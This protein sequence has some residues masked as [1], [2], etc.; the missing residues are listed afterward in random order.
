MRAS[1]RFRRLL[2]LL[3]TALSAGLTASLGFWQLGRADQK[4]QIEADLLAK[5]AEPPLH[6]SDL[7]QAEAMTPWINR[8]AR[9][10][11]EWVTQATVFLDN[12]QMDGR[13]GFY[14]VTP[15]RLSGDGRWLL[16]QRGWVPRDFQDRSRLPK[17]PTPEGVVSVSGRIAASPSRVYALGDGDNGA[18]RQNL[19]V[20]AF[21]REHGSSV[22]EGTLVQLAPADDAMP[23]GLLR[24]WPAVASNVQKH[25]GYAFQWFGLCALILFLYVWFQFISPH[26]RNR[27]FDAL[28]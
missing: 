10:T 20:S 6:N 9:F 17:V 13:Q 25:Y 21:A 1:V 3:V 14:V 28:R 24:N 11:G 18:I 22:L 5:T 16:V 26:R 4:L 12:R 7:S 23:D 8:Q 19:D 15:L 27:E 2:V